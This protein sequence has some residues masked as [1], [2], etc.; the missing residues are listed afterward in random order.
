MGIAFAPDSGTA[1][2]LGYS[3]VGTNH[4]PNNQPYPAWIAAI[5]VAAA[6][7]V[8][9]RPVKV[10]GIP[11]DIAVTPDGGVMYVCLSPPE[12]P[13][14]SPPLPGAIAIVDPQTYEVL[15]VFPYSSSRV[16]FSPDGRAVYAAASK[17]GVA[18]IDTT[19]QA[20]TAWVDPGLAPERVAI[21]PDG[22]FLYATGFGSTVAVIDTRAAK[23]WGYLFVGALTGDI[24]V[25]EAPDLGCS[26]D[27][28][29]D[30][31]VTVDEILTLVNI[32]LGAEDVRKCST[33]EAASTQTAVAITEI[34]RAI[35]NA[36]HG[37]ASGLCGSAVCPHGQDC[38]NPLLRLPRD[39]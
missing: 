4:E 33:V 5:D 30:G 20:I 22:A 7:V 1:Y 13:Q 29:G 14:F 32:A 27:C 2:V 8:D 3:E 26:G 34:L 15:K 6:A 17:N 38:C 31:Q 36:L 37:C 11:A 10:D 24:A 28:D 9:T 18:V 25:G 39:L 21:R 19:A 16:V 23:V 35:N 12:V